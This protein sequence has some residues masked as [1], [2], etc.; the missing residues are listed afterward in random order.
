METL[1]RSY[2]WILNLAPFLELL[3]DDA[4][5]LDKDLLE[6]WGAKIEGVVSAGEKNM[7]LL[8]L[9]KLLGGG[10]LEEASF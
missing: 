8:V 9:C 5:L 4:R 10:L 6:V 3:F 1:K 2:H 7:L